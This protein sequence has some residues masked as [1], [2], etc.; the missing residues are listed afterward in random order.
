MKGYFYDGRF[1]IKKINYAKIL[2]DFKVCKVNLDIFGLKK[3]SNFKEYGMFLKKI[4]SLK[5][6]KSF[7]INKDL[8]ILGGQDLDL[9]ILDFTESF[10]IGEVCE[11]D[12]IEDLEKIE[13]LTLL[14][15]LIRYLA[16][17]DILKMDKDIK[18]IDINS[19]YFFLK[20][21]DKDKIYKFLRCNFE[22]SN[23]FDEYVLNLTQK[24]FTHESLFYNKFKLKR[25]MKIGYDTAT[26]L[27]LPSEDG[28]YYERN[29]FS[30]SVETK[31]LIQTPNDLAKLRSYYFTLLK[32]LLE[33]NIS[34]YMKIELITLKNYE[35]FDNKSNKSYF[36]KNLKKIS[37]DIDVYL[38]K[39]RF[40]DGEDMIA[41]DSG[42]EIVELVNDLIF[43]KY[44]L[45][46]KGIGEVTTEYN[47]QN[48]NIF[49]LNT[50]DT[51]KLLYDGY[52]E[53]K[54]RCGLISNGFNLEEA[55][56]NKKIAI[57]R[58]V[59][60]L[61]I[62]E[63]LQNTDISKLHS[64]YNIFEGVSCIHFKNEKIR[65]IT[66]LKDGK[67]NSE[68]CQIFENC[69]LKD[70]FNSLIEKFNIKIDYDKSK[71]KSLDI[72]FMKIGKK[73]IYI[74]DTE[75]RL[76]FD[77]NK[78]TDHYK[79]SIESGTKSMARGLDSFLGMTMAIRLNRKEQMYYSFYDTGIDGEEV[80][81]PNIKKL[82]TDKKL[83]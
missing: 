2:K 33:N 19:I 59:E 13:A 30:K 36:Q 83:S 75:L 47:K 42:Q 44:S 77:S 76:Y 57:K 29:P 20:K 48:W 34:K 14:N 82:I 41:K 79:K 11:I 7:Y 71:I 50:T 80:F 8:Y 26:R 38:I 69:S 58:V 54:K 40:K 68:S 45:R 70:E 5:G 18:Y 32:D 17:E 67:I 31:F 21:S 23:N 55:G 25:T 15:L 4:R 24:T 9:N 51:S 52:R 10:I 46:N 39:D 49:L 61:F 16:Y 53:I 64:R 43:G 1:K 6:L 12:E 27:L 22:K 72:K 81:S 65:K 35:H 3:D 60:E 74:L 66:V 62:K 78:F 37:K 63:Q 56:K 73:D 28:K